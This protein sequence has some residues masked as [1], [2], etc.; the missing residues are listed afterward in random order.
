MAGIFTPDAGNVLINGDISLLSGVG[1]GMNK[2]LT[3]KIFTFMAA[4][5]DIVKKQWIH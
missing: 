2:H 1:Q 3:E 4:Y 5:L